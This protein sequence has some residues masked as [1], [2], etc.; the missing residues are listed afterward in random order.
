MP[1]KVLKANCETQSLQSIVRD[2]IKNSNVSKLINVCGIAIKL[3][4]KPKMYDQ[5]TYKA[6]IRLHHSVELHLSDGMN[7]WK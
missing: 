5:A 7:N 6:K 4:R 1:G 2:G 3:L